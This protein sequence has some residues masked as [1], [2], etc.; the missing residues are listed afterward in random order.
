MDT[1]VILPT[2]N[3]EDSIQET[4]KEIPETVNGKKPSIHVIDGGSSD[5]TIQKASKT[6]AEVIQQSYRGGK[7][8]GMR[9]ALDTIEAD[10]YVFLDA[11]STYSAEEIERLVEPIEEDGY[12]HVSGARFKLREPESF[13]TL[14]LY[15]NKIYSGFF[16][17]LTGKKVEDVLTGYRAVSK[18]LIDDINLESSGFEIETEMVYRTLASG[19]ELKEVDITYR[20][21][22]G[23]SKLNEFVDG[24][25]IM[26]YLFRLKFGSR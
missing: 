18:E 12:H 2:L 6:K 10:I 19:Y 22:K 8:A 11:D 1:A 5:T 13:D 26:S 17:L 9:E 23:E 15:L 7:G 4:V 21:R 3:E 14:N 16:S 20:P 25:K 24:F